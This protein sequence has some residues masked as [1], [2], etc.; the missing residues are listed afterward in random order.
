[1]E[2]F[3]AEPFLVIWCQVG[4]AWPLAVVMVMGFPGG[5]VVKNLPTMQKTRAGDTGQSLGWD[6]PLEM[7]MVTH[8]SILAW[9]I[10]WT[11]KPGG[12]QFMGLQNSQA[13]QQLN[14]KKVMRGPWRSYFS[15]H[16]HPSKALTAPIHLFIFLLWQWKAIQTLASSWG[17]GFSW[18]SEE[19]LHHFQVRIP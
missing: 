6:N 3:E 17:W 18:L 4:Y 14:N 10:P 19:M 9:K 1:M 16:G 15:F 8:C 12:L 2:S 7:K 11:E 5:S 13:W